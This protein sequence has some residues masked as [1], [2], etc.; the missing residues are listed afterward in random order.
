VEDLVA[1]LTAKD[2]EQRLSDAG[3]LAALARTVRSAITSDGQA[4][5]QRQA[6]AISPVGGVAAPGGVAGAGGVPD[7]ARFP[8][9]AAGFRD[10]AGLPA[11]VGIDLVRTPADGDFVGNIPVVAPPWETGTSGGPG[12]GPGSALALRAPV[13]AH[14]TVALRDPR[15]ALDVSADR[16]ARTVYGSLVDTDPFAA[17]DGHVRPRLAGLRQAGQLMAPER[18][19]GRRRA[20]IGIGALVLVGGA[21]LTGAVASGV[22]HAS[23]M[24]NRTPLRPSLSAVQP[25]APAHTSP[26]AAAPGKGATPAKHAK[27]YAPKHARTSAP[28]TTAPGTTAPTPVPSTAPTSSTGTGSGSSAPHTRPSPSHSTPVCIL[29]ILCS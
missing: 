25:N 18:P 21:G 11:A 27:P 13:A 2:P 3:E 24:A 29:G 14:G 10:A 19:R 22:L 17:D 23:P 5:R 12:P 28:A 6:L 15:T 1:R 4:S 26:R 16:G 8:E 20:A 7:A 9:A